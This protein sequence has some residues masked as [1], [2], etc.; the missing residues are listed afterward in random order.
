VINANGG[1]RNTGTLE[2]TNGGTLVLETYTF[3]N[4]SG[5]I[6][7]GAHS[8]VVLNAAT[9][10][11]GTL[12]SVSG[13]VINEEGGATLDALTI[14]SGSTVDVLNGQTMTLE[15]TITN[16][17]TINIGPGSLDINGNV[18]LTALGKVILANKN[19]GNYIEGSGTLT[20]QGTIEG[21]GNIGQ[22]TI[23]LINTGTIFADDINELIIDTGSVGFSNSSGS[24]NGTLKVNKNDTLN[25]IGP[26]NNFS[27]TTL[28]GGIYYIAGALEFTGADIVTNA[29]TIT[30]TGPTSKI[31]N[32]SNST[33]AL[34]NSLSVNAIEGSFTLAGS[35]NFTTLG[36]FSNAGKV[37]ISSGSTFAVGGTDSYTQTAGTT[38]VSG[39]LAVSS[40]GVLN[41]SGGSV[42]GIGTVTGNIDLTGGLLSPGAASKKAGELTI[43]GAYTQSGSGAFDVD[44]GGTTAGTQ[45]D[46]LNITSTASL[47]GT[48]NVDL[49]SGFKPAVGQTFD[50]MDYTSE[51]GAFSTA[52]LPKLTGGDT[53]SITYN[54][55]DLVLTVDGPAV[56]EGT[57]NG[58]PAKRVSRAFSGTSGT[59]AASTHEP[60]S[61]LSRVTCFAA[62]MIGSASCG[63]KAFVVTASHGSDL[64]EVI[65]AGTELRSAHNNVMVAT[66]SISSGRGG[67]SHETSAS[68]SAMARLYVCAYLP[69]YASRT[70]G[71]D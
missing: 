29:A 27:G 63:D 58:A 28:S 23:G 55:T 60:T 14:S 49:I 50:I 22:G 6:I 21:A 43:S 19:Q 2:A 16:N 20:N 61:I 51:T 17:G 9:I 13:G 36:A 15:G 39:T 24:K 59:L 40:P 62:R 41:V 52:N 33:D 67:A 53:W 31:I 69:S 30:L 11:G 70:L 4:A 68:A 35:R 18:T 65:S 34:A 54:A 45:Y 25:I 38:T 32:S 56:A 3:S 57:V 7:A 47:G 48:L 66:R 71:C 42:F 26:I 64:Q 12:T 46:V 5:T 37:T 10:V 1:T 8:S 44:L